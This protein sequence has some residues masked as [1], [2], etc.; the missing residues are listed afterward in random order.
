MPRD[1]TVTARHVRCARMVQA[2][3]P[4]A[5]PVQACGGRQAR[6]HGR[7]G[8]AG[9]PGGRGLTGPAT[10][11]ARWVS[12]PRSAM[13]RYASLRK[14]G[15]EE[16][17]SA[18]Q[19]PAAAAPSCSAPSPATMCGSYGSSGDAASTPCGQQGGWTGT[20]GTGTIGR[21]GTP[22]GSCNVVGDED[23]AHQQRV[24]DEWKQPGQREHLRATYRHLAAVSSQECLSV[25]IRRALLT[26]CQMAAVAVDEVGAEKFGWWSCS[27]GPCASDEPLRSSSRQRGGEQWRAASSDAH[28]VCCGSATKTA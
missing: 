3:R 19:R 2:E 28:E 12:S 23:I 5:R 21:R 27:P 11:H 1:P 20:G 4:H 22:S 6:S 13:H 24:G 17:E 25:R 9:G 10:R 26:C 16:G 8:S 18:H 7:H 14:V 15:W